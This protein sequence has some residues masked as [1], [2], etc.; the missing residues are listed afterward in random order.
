M[1]LL[2]TEAGY[3]LKLTADHRVFTANRGDLPACELTRDDRVLLGR[4]PFG[5]G[6][7]P[8]IPATL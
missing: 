6:R 8:A 5:R 7:V 3:K 1:Y 2:R 4:P